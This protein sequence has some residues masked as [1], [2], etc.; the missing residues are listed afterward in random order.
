MGNTGGLA[1]GT[2]MAAAAIAAGFLWYLPLLALV[3]VIATVSVIAQV[4]SFK[5]TGRRII[6]MSPLHNHFLVSGWRETPLAL[7]F[8]A[9]SLVAAVLVLPLSRPAASA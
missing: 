9:G 5:M 1:V 6:K 3:F 4:A 7:C 2:A 8:W